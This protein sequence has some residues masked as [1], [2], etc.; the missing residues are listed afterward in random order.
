[1]DILLKDTETTV[2]NVYE[3]SIDYEVLIDQIFEHDRA[4]CWW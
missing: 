2:V 4:V 3:D 1:M